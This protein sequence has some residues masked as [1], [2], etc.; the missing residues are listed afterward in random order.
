MERALPFDV[1][2]SL[3]KIR[4]SDERRHYAVEK[5]AT[6]IRLEVGVFTTVEDARRAVNGLLAAGFPKDKVTVVC[7]DETKERY[8]REFEHQEPAGTFT[9]TA[10]IAGGTIGALLG[11]ATIIA[12][13]LATGSLALWAAGPITAW[14]GGVAGGLVGAMMTRGVEKE[15]ANFYQQAVL[16]GQILV[17]AEASDA[18]GAS[19]GE[20][21][22]I[23]AEA[24]AKPLA[25]P[26]G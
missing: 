25:L 3:S 11:G 24:G 9:P 26:Q 1:A 10:S 6:Q 18:R 21:A 22:R 2:Q 16:E 17:A 20:A 8:F 13:A 23:L 19:L 12:S 7:S 15:L 14:A 4:V 5:T